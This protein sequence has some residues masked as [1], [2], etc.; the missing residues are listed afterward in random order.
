MPSAQKPS[1]RRYAAVGETSEACLAVDQVPEPPILGERR[2]D[3]DGRR[4][5][6][7]SPSTIQ[8]TVVM[9]G[10]THLGDWHDFTGRKVKNE[11]QC[12]CASSRDYERIGTSHIQDPIILIR[13]CGTDDRSCWAFHFTRLRVELCQHSTHSNSDPL[14][15]RHRRHRQRDR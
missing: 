6:R 9:E 13:Q 5:R 4:R 1:W 8:S 14:R 3:P 10:L 2:R 12:G 11:S 7:C 15:C